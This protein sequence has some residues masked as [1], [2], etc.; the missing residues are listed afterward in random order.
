VR[1][2][3]PLHW[4]PAG[5]LFW[6]S[7]MVVGVLIWPGANPLC[8]P[9]RARP[10]WG[11][12]WAS[13]LLPRPGGRSLSTISPENRAEIGGVLAVNRAGLAE[14]TG[15]SLARINVLASPAQRPYSGCPEPIPGQHSPSGRTGKGSA[16]WWYP[17][18]AARAWAASLRVPGTRLPAPDNP[19]ELITA[20]RYRDEVLGVTGD[21]WNFYVRRAQGAWQ[22]GKPGPELA[23][24]VDPNAP[25]RERRW[26]HGDA[27]AHQNNRPGPRR[28]GRPAKADRVP[29][30]IPEPNDPNEVLSET[31]LRTRIMNPPVSARY[32]AKLVAASQDAWAQGQDGELPRPESAVHHAGRQV[33][34]WRAGRA[35]AWW[36]GL[37]AEA[38]SR[39][40]PPPP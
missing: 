40:A 26:R 36:N 35:A 27:V 32:F 7:R 2:S 5:A 38:A 3:P 19:N 33:Y 8:P 14:L 15:L 39:P 22:Q 6:S 25:G 28:G 12:G 10:L 4:P 11:N 37:A 9:A 18:D 1:F 34:R 31:A 30:P 24:P 21:T 16:E 29:Q 13:G 17:E 20:M 23:L